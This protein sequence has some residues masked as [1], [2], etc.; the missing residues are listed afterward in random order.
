MAN[1]NKVLLMG[2]LTRDLELKYM[3]NQTAVCDFGLAVNRTWTGQDGVKKEEVTFIDCTAFSK[4]A[5]I[6]SKYKKKGDPLFVE[7]RLKLDQW[8][9][10]DGTKRYKMRVIV[11]NFQFLNRGQGA[12]GGGGY[13]NDATGGNEYGGEPAAGGAPRQQAPRPAAQPYRQ[14]GRPGAAPPT[15]RPAA[16]PNY[17]AGD[18]PAPDEA[19]PLTDDEIPF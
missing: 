4:Q 6:L 15:Q 8:D 10:Q 7:G 9:A 13:S 12:P 16:A 2:N 11:E 14:G 5:E 18:A 19:P 17:D 3:P 1:L